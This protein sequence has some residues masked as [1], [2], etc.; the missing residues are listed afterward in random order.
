MGLVSC[1]ETSVNIIA[2]LMFLIAQE[3]ADFI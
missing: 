2:N 3:N 1:H